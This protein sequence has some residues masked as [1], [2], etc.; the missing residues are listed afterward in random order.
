M[1]RRDR[2]VKDGNN[3][4]VEGL[5][6][7]AVEPKRESIPLLSRCCRVA[8]EIGDTCTSFGNG[9]QD[10][11]SRIQGGCRDKRCGR[12]RRARPFR[13]HLKLSV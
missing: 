2:W 10:A 8:L 5:G 12:A 6:V 4:G 3:F 1:R 9:R 13:P 11:V 7:V